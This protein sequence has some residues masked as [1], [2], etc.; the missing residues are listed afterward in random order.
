MVVTRVF[1]RFVTENFM[2]LIKNCIDEKKNNYNQISYK[3]FINE[4][5]SVKNSID[6]NPILVYFKSLIVSPE[7]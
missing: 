2:R 5:C 7:Y 4:N 6:K 3:S 1:Y